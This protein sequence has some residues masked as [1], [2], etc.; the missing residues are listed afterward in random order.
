MSKVNE[1]IIGILVED[2]FDEAQ[3]VQEILTRYGCS[4][5][6]RLGLHNVNGNHC[7]QAGV[8]IL[9]L[10]PD[11]EKGELLVMAMKKLEGVQVKEMLF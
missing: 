5:K 4:I 7:S 3:Q 8:I 9:Q 11:D 6:T 1:H 10:I 2:R